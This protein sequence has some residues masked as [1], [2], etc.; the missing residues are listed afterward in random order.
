[1]TGVGDMADESSIGDV[2]IGAFCNLLGGL[3]IRLWQG[4]QGDRNNRHV[5][6]SF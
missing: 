3:T 6:L 2:L 5:K 1:V 4:Q